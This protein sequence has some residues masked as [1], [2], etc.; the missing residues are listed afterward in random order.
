MYC[1]VDVNSAEIT[2][3]QLLVLIYMWKQ[4]H[5]GVHYSMHLRLICPVVL[6]KHCTE[7]V[8]LEWK[9]EVTFVFPTG[10][11][12]ENSR[13]KY[14]LKAQFVPHRRQYLQQE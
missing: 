14:P 2:Y 12:P 9:A 11:S 5:Y 7:Y 8:P 13:F 3:S 1:S 10:P 6:G 4:N